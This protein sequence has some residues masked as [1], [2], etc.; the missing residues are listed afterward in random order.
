VTNKD[1]WLVFNKIDL[2][3]IEDSQ[4]IIDEV[5]NKISWHGPVY[6]IS[7]VTRVGLDSLCNDILL[8]LNIEQE[9]HY[10]H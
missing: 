8:H 1:R 6:A 5:T 9:K 10:E 2:F 3:S 7:T 4:K